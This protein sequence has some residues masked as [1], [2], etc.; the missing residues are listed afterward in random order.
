MIPKIMDETKLLTELVSDKTCIGRLIDCTSCIVEEER[1]GAYTLTAEVPTTSK[2]YSKLKLGGILQVKANQ[3]DDNQLFRIETITEPY[4]DMVI[5]EANHISYDL[6][7]TS[8]APFKAVTGAG[9]AMTMIK[10]NMT[11]GASFTLA[12]SFIDTTGTFKNEIP[13][14]ARSLFG[15][16]SGSLIDV[17]GGEWHFDNL[18]CT[19]CNK[20][21]TDRGVSLRYGKN[22]ISLEQE[23]NIEN[24]YTHVMPYVTTSD[25]DAITGTLHTLTE[26]SNDNIR[27][28]N[29]DLSSKFNDAEETP[30]AD[31]IDKACDAYIKANDL[32]TPKVSIELEYID[33]ADI[34]EYKQLFMSEKVALCDTVHVY[35]PKLNINTTAKVVSTKWNVL[36]ERYDKIDIGDARSSLAETINNISSDSKDY[37]D[38]KLSGVDIALDKIRSA[39]GGNVSLHDS[40]DETNSI[41]R[42]EIYAYDGDT[43]A[44]SNKVLRINNAGIAGT[45]EGVN[46]DYHVAITTDGYINADYI[47]AGT[48]NGININGTNI[49]GSTIT[50]ANDANASQI[51]KL[52][53]GKLWTTNSKGDSGVYIANQQVSLYSWTTSGHQVG[54]LFTIEN[55]QGER[56][57]SLLAN[58]DDGL[59]IGKISGSGSYY[60]LLLCQ[61]NGDIFMQHEVDGGYAD[62]LWVDEDIIYIYNAKGGSAIKIH[63]GDS[64]GYGVEAYNGS[65]EGPVVVSTNSNKLSLLWNGSQLKLYSGT[66]NVWSSSDERLKD[67]IKPIDDKYMQAMANIELKQFNFK[68]GKAWNKDVTHFGVIAQ[69]VREAFQAQG[70]DIEHDAINGSYEDEGET[71]FDISKDEFLMA[72]LAY[73]EERIKTLEARLE[74]LEKKV[75]ND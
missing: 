73:D 65:Y 20:R 11:G 33:L 72:R 37:A 25:G 47:N 68:E 48:I 21:G 59:F 35:F 75:S 31:D 51:V 30:T 24:V 10:K 66:S 41:I 9:N 40:K 43:I 7:K 42:N 14:P 60:P 2:Y 22:I 44:T 12:T 58:S 53:Q 15:G 50:S 49:A 71:Y 34:D 26:V 6:K 38:S 46:G 67:N 55:Y 1:N 69:E 17:F 61:K 13:Q 4:D 62:I 23:K 27:V 5:I 36:K 52:D 63:S 28:Y 29:L 3:D 18:T 64:F 8:V 56:Y 54:H 19:L 16:Q 74:E 32:T 39:S 45:D 70:L 57:M